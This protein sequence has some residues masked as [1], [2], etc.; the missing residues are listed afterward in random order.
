[1]SE[2]KKIKA[3]KEP[4][5]AKA[6]KGN[7]KART[8]AGAE[9]LT[10]APPGIVSDLDKKCRWLSFEESQII[11]DRDDDSTD[12]YFIIEGKVKIMD[13]LADDQEIALAE[14]GPGA[15][16]GELSAVDASKR[17][18]RVTALEDTTLATITSSDFRDLLM[19]VPGISI[20]LLKRFAGL[21]RTLNTRITA[22]S[23]MT[24]HQRVYYELIRMSEPN[25]Q[26]D[27][28]WV[29]HYLPKHEEIAS[30]SGTSRE[31]VAMAI[32][33]LARE[34]IVGRKHKS[35]IIKDHDRLQMLLNL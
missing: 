6:V 19:E 35:L 15:S 7:G 3:T 16:F 27:G 14:L 31:D 33:H 23:T 17:S 4:K 30:W 11:V 10:E 13:F 1:M 18:A 28:S 5:A 29:I 8:L 22:L 12:V 32:G 9:L 20:M 25:P 26:G 2:K 21:I 24:P 34:G